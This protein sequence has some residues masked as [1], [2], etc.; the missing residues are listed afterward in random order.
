MRGEIRELQKTLGITA[1]YVTHDQEEALSISDRIAVMRGGRL[2]Q[3]GAPK[4]LY[5]R[6]A[7][8]FR[9][10]LPRHDQ[11]SRWHGR[12]ATGA[13]RRS[14]GS[15]PA[16]SW[17][18]SSPRPRAPPSPSRFGPRHSARSPRATPP[19]G[20]LR[21]DRRR[22]D[23]ARV[24]RRADAN[25]GSPRQRH[26]AA[27]RVPRHAA[28]RHGG[29]RRH[30]LRLRPGAHHRFRVF[31]RM[32]SL[33]APRCAFRWRSPSWRSRSSACS[34]STRCRGVQRQLSRSERQALNAR[35]LRQ[36]PSSSGFYQGSVL[37]SL[38]IGAA[39]TL[40]TT[41]LAVPLAFAL[42]RL[43]IAGKSAL[44]VARRPAARAAVLRLRP[45]RSCSCSGAPASSGSGC[46]IS[47]C[48]SPRSTARGGI[49]AV[50][51]LTLYPYVLLP[52][53][54]GL[55]GDRRLGRGGEPE[56]RRVALAGFLRPSRLPLVMPSDAR[57]RA[58]RL[59]RD[60]GEF[61]RAV[62]A[63]RGQADPRGR[64]L[65]AVRRRDRPE[66]GLGR[67]A[68]GAARRLDGARRS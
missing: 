13:G 17:Y 24:S 53:L 28:R 15:A 4:E 62:R 65:Q 68:R 6:P 27:S 67:R 25:R 40:V 41:A 31:R 48:R 38:G 5:R 7:T 34:S 10:G 16:P 12:R 32:T 46:A 45:M 42:A 61:R 39:A 52:T 54:A 2:E 22:I 50:Y 20:G 66:P 64:G 37:N 1:I 35:E 9:R 43:P 51:A 49:V 55:Q 58:A 29:R 21:D 44:L 26:A 11:S 60:A 18:R 63:R 14:C 8:P 47:A 30:R 57:R 3:V 36:D 56:S 59:H 33:A 23:A 19:P